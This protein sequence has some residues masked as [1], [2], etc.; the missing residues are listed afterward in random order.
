M[1]NS[2]LKKIFGI[3][4]MGSSISLLLLSLF[5]WANQMI[6]LQITT[7]YLTQVKYF[8]IALVILGLGL[9]MWSFWTLRNWWANDKLCTKG[10]FKYFRHPM[11]A[12]WITFISPGIALYLNSWVYFIWVLLLHPIWHKLV[13]KEESTMINTFGDIYKDYA[14][15]T[16]RF[17]PKVIIGKN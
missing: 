3:G 9:H 12:A 15:Q 6:G 7:V 1:M 8:G 2:R 10:P 11:Y 5:A 13:K 16:G 4:P 14:R 17:I